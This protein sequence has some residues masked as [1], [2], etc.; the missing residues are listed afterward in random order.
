MMKFKAPKAGSLVFICAH[1]RLATV[2]EYVMLY[3]I[4][5]IIEMYEHGFT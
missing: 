3:T 2:V 1:V 4:K 5:S